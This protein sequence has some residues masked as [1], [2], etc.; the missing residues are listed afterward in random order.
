MGAGVMEKVLLNISAE[1]TEPAAGVG[2]E[3]AWSAAAAVSHGEEDA[4]NPGVDGDAV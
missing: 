2:G 1:W 3:V 4:V